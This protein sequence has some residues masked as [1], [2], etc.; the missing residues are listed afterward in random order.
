MAFS[1]GVFFSRAWA[2]AWALALA[3]CSGVVALTCSFAPFAPA[4]PLPRL[5]ARPRHMVYCGV[6]LPKLTEHARRLRFPLARREARPRPLKMKKMPA[7]LL[8]LCSFFSFAPLL[9]CSRA[10]LL[11]CSFAPLTLCPFTPFLLRARARVL[12]CSCV[13][14]LFCTG[15]PLLLGLGPRPRP[16]PWAVVV[17]LTSFLAL[18]LGLWFPLGFGPWPWFWFS[19][20]R[21]LWP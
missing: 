10:P 17:A 20:G 19:L 6:K 1:F 3:L 11:L 15:A 8:P 4:V 5:R 18:W 16:W 7:R 9:L 14:L 2:F 12:V 21:S 13:P